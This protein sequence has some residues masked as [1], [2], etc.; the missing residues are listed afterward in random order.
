LFSYLA[1]EILSVKPGTPAA[2][3]WALEGLALFLHQAATMAD[4]PAMDDEFLP[5][6][7]SW[8]ARIPLPAAPHLHISDA[9]RE[10]SVLAQRIFTRPDTRDSF[11]RHLL[12][13]WPST[14]AAEL[15]AM[16][17]DLGYVSGTGERD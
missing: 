10:L 14:S 8:V 7:G 15:Q 16:L 5:E 4:G 13:H 17:A 11:A 2:F 12:A 1:R 3:A 9:H 6:I